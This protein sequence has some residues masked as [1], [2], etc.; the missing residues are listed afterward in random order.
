VLT[1]VVRVSGSGRLEE[2]GER[3]RWLMVRD[4]DASRAEYTEHH[5][6][7]VLEYRFETRA[8]IP[9][10]AFATA[11][12]EF[13][14]LRVEAEW[15]NAAQ[16][17]RGRVVIENGRPIEHQSGPLEDDHLGVVVEL[18]LGGE[19][20]FAMA[21]ARRGEGWLGYCA[22]GSRHAYF[23]AEGSGLRFAEDA[24][25]CWTRRVEGGRAEPLDEP[26]DA[27]LLAALEDVAFRF[28]DDWLWFDA[29]AEAQTA[30]ERRR[31]AD[32]GWPVQGANLR[33][34]RLLAIGAGGRLDAL[35]PQARPL[36]DRLRGAWEAIR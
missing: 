24:G 33:A 36:L 17:L 12:E 15:A 21:C 8:G 10:P 6:E 22:S 14:E 4:P 23:L 25:A 7:G 27:A 1:A 35:A 2:F 26:V 13:P 29:A 20:A 5:A 34:E 31:Y 30:L 11:S 32:H 19:L 16:G 18:G 28:A 9:F 3:V